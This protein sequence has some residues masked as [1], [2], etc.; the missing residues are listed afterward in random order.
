[1]TSQGWAPSSTVRAYRRWADWL[2]PRNVRGPVAEVEADGAGVADFGPIG[3]ERGT[4]LWLV[5]TGPQD[6]PRGVRSSAPGDWQPRSGRTR[7]RR[8]ASLSP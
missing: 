6:E 1:M 8:R 5:G 3:L 2:D 7:R 4:P